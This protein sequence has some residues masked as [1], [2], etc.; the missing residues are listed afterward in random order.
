[1]RKSKFFCLLL[2]CLLLL[3]ACGQN[4]PEVSLYDQGLEVVALMEDVMSNDAYLD[5]L[6]ASEELRAIIDNAAAGD[7]SVP[8]AVYSISF[9][10]SVFAE[11][12]DT[13][14][15]PES[16][17][18]VVTH[19][20]I[21]AVPPQ[22][23]A[24]GGAQVLAASSLCTVG[25]TFVSSQLKEDILYLY[26]FETGCPVAVVFTGGE[27]QTVTATAN[28]IF[29]QGFDVSDPQSIQDFFGNEFATVTL[30]TEAD[31]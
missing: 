22:V 7:Y 11:L 26:V 28:A 15:I 16:L 17:L 29:Y 6:S 18:D 19:R 24:A 14:T 25:K 31:H 5:M 1:M 27:D 3:T 21:S 30:L 20:L 10:S 23:N 4:H 12:V 2:V 13:S 9:S 8:M